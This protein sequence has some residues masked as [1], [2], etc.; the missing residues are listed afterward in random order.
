MNY[1]AH[2]YLS[3][4]QSELLVG[5]M[6][7]DHVKGKKQYDFPEG[8]RK[9]IILHRSIDNYTDSHLQVSKAKE[10]F[11]ASYRLYAAPLI[12]IVFDHYLASTQFD[13][14]ELF[15][16]SQGVYQVLEEYWDWLPE[17]FQQLFPYMKEHNWLYN[18]RHLA[19]IERSMN[20]LIRR[21]AYINDMQTAI[22]LLQQHYTELGEIFSVFF[23][24]VKNFAKHESERLIL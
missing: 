22:H 19:G 15:T 17:R 5:N 16:F 10:Y 9:G 4:G 20:G 6:I 7:S 24:D 23:P 2:A 12:D 1:L 3:F 8:I 11:R 14:E 13:E 18:Y 21:A